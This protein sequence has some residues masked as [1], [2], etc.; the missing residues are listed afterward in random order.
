MIEYGEFLTFTLNR[1]Q[2]VS[3]DNLKIAFSL[4][5]K[6]GTGEITTKEIKVK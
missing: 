4:F 3:F 1:K 2:M 5:D 6:D